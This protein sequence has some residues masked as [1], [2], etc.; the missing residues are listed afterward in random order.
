M[1]EKANWKGGFIMKLIMNKIYLVDGLRNANGIIVNEIHA[2]L[3]N[4]FYCGGFRLP[5]D[6]RLSYG[7]QQLEGMT[8]NYAELLGE[9]PIRKPRK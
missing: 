2:Y 3:R 9:I 4:G 5:P 7:N 8:R 6:I 1:Q